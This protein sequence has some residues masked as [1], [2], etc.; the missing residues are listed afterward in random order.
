[1]SSTTTTTPSENAT[2]A[3]IISTVE[4]ILPMVLAGRLQ[5]L[6]TTLQ[7]DLKSYD[8]DAD[9]K[10]AAL[11]VALDKEETSNPYVQQ[12]VTAAL[13]VA[14]AAGLTV[15]TEDAVFAELKLVVDSGISVMQAPA[16][17]KS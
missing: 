16:P 2:V 11:K 1:M 3:G 7:A 15:P 8:A 17:A 10:L 6:N 14:K 13:S 12:I 9:A 4:T 5:G